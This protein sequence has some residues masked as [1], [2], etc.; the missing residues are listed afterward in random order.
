MTARLL[1]RLSGVWHAILETRPD[2]ISRQTSPGSKTRHVLADI[3][4]CRALSIQTRQSLRKP[5]IAGR[6]TIGES[7]SAQEHILDSPRANPA[8]APQQARGVSGGEIPQLLG[9]NLA[10]R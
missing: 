2:M 9:R 4:L 6:K 10:G 8:N 3:L 5:C 7:E 1:S